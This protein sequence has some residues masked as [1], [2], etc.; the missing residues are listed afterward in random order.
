MF[1]EEEPGK[2]RNWGCTICVIFTI[3]VANLCIF[4]I[5]RVLLDSEN[6]FDEP[7]V[8]GKPTVPSHISWVC[9]GQLRDDL[10]KFLGIFALTF[11]FGCWCCFCCAGHFFRW[12]FCC[13]CGDA[14]NVGHWWDGVMRRNSLKD[15]L[16]SRVGTLRKRTKAAEDVDLESGGDHEARIIAEIRERPR[17]LTLQTAQGEACIPGVDFMQVPVSLITPSTV[18]V[19][20]KG[21]RNIAFSNSSSDLTSEDPRSTS[22]ESQPLSSVSPCSPSTEFTEVNI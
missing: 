6:E 20:D 22:S 12:V 4:V 10:T 19:V 14:C 3:C 15:R 18:A 16:V 8:Q 1:D 7:I 2:P 21:Q 17:R 11:C 9:L 5:L 13:D